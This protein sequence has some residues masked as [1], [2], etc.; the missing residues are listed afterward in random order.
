MFFDDPLNPNTRPDWRWQQAAWLRENN[1]Y[2]RKG[3]HDPYVV[4][5]KSYQS[6][7]AKATTA[8]DPAAM[9]ELRME[10]P[11]LFWADR[12]YEMNFKLPKWHIEAR[13]LA[14]CTPAQIAQFLKTSEDVIL[15][16]ERAFFNVTPHL[17]NKGYIIDTVMGE[18]YHVGIKDR[19]YDLL[20]KMFGYFLGP[21]ALQHLIYPL[22]HVG[23]I[24]DVQQVSPALRAGIK[25]Q[26]EVKAYRAW[27]TIQV[28]HNQVNVIAL[29]NEMLNIERQAGETERTQS[30]FVQ[31]LNQALGALGLHTDEGDALAVERLPYYDKSGREL[32]SSE[33]IQV[34]FGKDTEKHRDLATLKF[35]SKED[36]DVQD[37]ESDRK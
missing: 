25:A 16:Y 24:D 21:V 17:D 18:S 26:A 20:W 35:P 7:K 33:L 29:W 8:G 4:V 5:L 32:R 27:A 23:Y 15:W 31:N 22:D 34:A 37:D 11:G 36:T 28:D 12:C 13:L 14:R 2:A 1:K 19:Q 3:T 10:Y 9:Y 30:M 6:A